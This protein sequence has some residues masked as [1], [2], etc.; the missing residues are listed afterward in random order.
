MVLYIYIHTFV[1]YCYG[2]KTRH[3]YKTTDTI[4]N[5]NILVKSLLLLLLNTAT[6][7][8]P[9]GL[10]VNHRRHPAIGISPFKLHFTWIIPHLSACHHNQHQTAYQIEFQNLPTFNIGRQNTTQSTNV[11]HPIQLIP[12]KT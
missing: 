11:F 10:L 1:G 4:G 5:M 12:T 9:S 2:Y 7:T 6:A 8:S 3:R